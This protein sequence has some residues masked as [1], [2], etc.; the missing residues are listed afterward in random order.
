MRFTNPCH[1]RWLIKNLYYRGYMFYTEDDVTPA[2][3]EA[4][5]IFGEVGLMHYDTGHMKNQNIVT[6]EFGKVW[7]GDVD[8]NTADSM[9][10]ALSKAIG[11][12]VYM[13]PQDSWE[14]NRHPSFK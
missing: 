7:Y 8:I 6:K 14:F 11:K 12:T 9:C 3:N 1:Q 2:V 10:V 4:V 13:L 5:K